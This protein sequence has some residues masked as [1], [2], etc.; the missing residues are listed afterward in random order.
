MNDPFATL[1]EAEFR[2]LEMSPK[3]KNSARNYFNLID[4]TQDHI[5]AI[6][7]TLGILFDRSKEE[8]T[9][10]EYRTYIPSILKNLQY[11]IESIVIYETYFPEMET[12]FSILENPRE[13][14]EIAPRMLEKNGEISSLLGSREKQYTKVRPFLEE[15]Y[16]D[17]MIDMYERSHS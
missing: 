5:I 3:N 1:I 10:E 12:Q 8:M 17:A 11:H 2:R 13:I 14:L 6:E 16:A 15:R 7:E 4:I 9:I